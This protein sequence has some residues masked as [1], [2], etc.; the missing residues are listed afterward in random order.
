[1]TIVHSAL[2]C[3]DV[4]LTCIAQALTTEA[5]ETMGLLLGDIKVHSFHAYCLLSFGNTDTANKACV[6]DTLL[7]G[8]WAYC[9]KEASVSIE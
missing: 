1:M 7:T 8:P 4:F 9:L 3:A 5:E 6:V 2:V